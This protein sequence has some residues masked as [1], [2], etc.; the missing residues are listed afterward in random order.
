M[1]SRQR[2][3]D[4]GLVCRNVVWSYRGLWTSRKNVSSP[5]SG[6]VS[7]FFLSFFCFFFCFFVYLPSTDV[8]SPCLSLGSLL[9][10]RHST[11]GGARTCCWGWMNGL[12]A[13]I[14]LNQTDDCCWQGR[15]AKEFPG[16]IRHEH[17]RQFPTLHWNLRHWVCSKESTVEPK[18]TQQMKKWHIPLGPP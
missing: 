8:L 11:G 1:F 18:A 9:G 5:S 10:L 4:G 7:S 2:Y 16:N 15:P 12:G 3:V 17:K 6:F 14:G 13:L